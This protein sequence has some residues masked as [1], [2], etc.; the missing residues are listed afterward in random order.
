MLYRDA[1]EHQWHAV[2][3]GVRVDAYAHAELAHRREA[4]ASGS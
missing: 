1:G 2:L 4:S 3:E